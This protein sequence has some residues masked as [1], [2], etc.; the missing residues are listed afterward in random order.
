MARN[1]DLLIH[2]ATYDESETARASEFYHATASQAGEA[3]AALNAKTLV[4]IHTSF[5]VYGCPGPCSRCTEKILRADPHTR[6]IWT[7]SK[8]H[9]AT[10]MTGT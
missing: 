1:A 3:A 2:D 9:S 5:A 4:L 8:C 10:K 6:T 7:W